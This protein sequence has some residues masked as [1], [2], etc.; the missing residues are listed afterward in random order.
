MTRALLL[1]SLAMA[2]CGGGGDAGVDGPILRPDSDGDLDFDGVADE[3]DNCPSSSNAFQGNEDGDSFGDACDPCPVVSDNAP[4]DGDADEVADACDPKPIIS[5]DR[6][7][8]FEGF[9]QGKPSGW[10][11]AGTWG[12]SNDQLTGNATGAGHFALIVTDRT[13]ETVTARITVATAA[14]ASSEVG[15]VDNKM[16]NG[17]PAVVCALTGTPAL[18][19]YDTGNRPGAVTQAFE[20]TAGQ[21]YEVRLTRENSTYTCTA[22]NVTSGMSATVSQTIS[23]VNTPFLS[24]LT[25][26]AASIRVEWFLVVESL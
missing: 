26:N 10:N 1:A 6:I 16:Q 22:R 21:T 9:H 19:L 17:T 8:F 2:A 13:R 23:L 3:I 15:V 14:G 20:L 11:E 24:G 25:L 7:A 18:A 5:G 12:G 4:S